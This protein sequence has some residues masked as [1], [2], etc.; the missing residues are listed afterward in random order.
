MIN[1]TRIKPGMGLMDLMI[2]KFNSRKDL[3]ASQADITHQMK[4]QSQVRQ[5]GTVKRKRMKGRLNVF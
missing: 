1:E 3:K 4:G 2:S 5:D